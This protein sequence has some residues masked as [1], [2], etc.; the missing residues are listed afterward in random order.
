[1]K[2]TF[3][4]EIK[5]KTLEENTVKCKYICTIFLEMQEAMRKLS[6]I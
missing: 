6:T 5:K 2:V 3:T 1:M 4:Q